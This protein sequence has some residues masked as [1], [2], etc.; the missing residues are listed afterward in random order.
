VQKDVEQ[1]QQK[2]E[3]ILSNAQLI[4]GNVVEITSTVKAQV[5]KVDSIVDSVKER[6]DSIIE[7]EK[8][9]QIEVEK[10]V[11]NVL[12]LVS[13]VNTGLRTFF[14]AL[15]GSKNNLSGRHK[16]YS[17]VSEETSYEDL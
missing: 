17:A 15:S 4:S 7:F 13:A 10:Q 1:I 16:S 6:T 11:Y 12:N 2:I 8:N 9:T 14:A 3:P 5:A